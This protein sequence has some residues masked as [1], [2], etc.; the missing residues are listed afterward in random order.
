VVIVGAGPAGPAR[1]CTP[2]RKGS[3]AD[4]GEHAP[5]GRPGRARGSRTIWDSPPGFLAWT[6]RPGAHQAQKFGA[7]WPS[8]ARPVRFNCDELPYRCTSSDGEVVQA[9]SIVIATGARYGSWTCPS[10]PV[11]RRRHLLQR[12]AHGGAV[13]QGRG[14]SRSWAAAI[15]QDKPPSSSPDRISR[16]R[17]GA[18]AQPS[19]RACPAT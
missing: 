18:R 13:V 7:E 4:P 11:S 6:R 1:R 2:R 16:A 10:S 17:R 19:R 9:R 3:M 12:D 15:Q 14:D 8:R 5:G